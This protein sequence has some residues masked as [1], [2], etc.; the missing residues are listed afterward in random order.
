VRRLGSAWEYGNAGFALAGYALGQTSWFSSFE[1]ALAA[2]VFGPAGMEETSFDPA[3][4]VG[5]AAGGVPVRE[6]YA[7]ARRPG[8]G[9]V[10]T[11]DDLLRFGRFAMGDPASLAATGRPVAA[12]ALGSRYGLGWNLTHRGRVR[13]HGGDWGG[14]HAALLLD[15]T[16]RLTVAVV[17]NDDAGEPLRGELAWS[18]FARAGGASRPRVMPALWTAAAIARQRLTALWGPG[19]RGGAA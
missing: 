14:C 1:Q 15:P 4:G 7:R 10:S 17:I 8:G 16:R 5:H 9:V 18:E 11:V 13:W 3:G 2:E 12:G 19:H 6:L